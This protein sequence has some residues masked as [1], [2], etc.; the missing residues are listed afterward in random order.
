VCNES[1]YHV[2]DIL[3]TYSTFC[4]IFKTINSPERR[5]S[6]QITGRALFLESLKIFMRLKGVL[7]SIEKWIFSQFFQGKIQKF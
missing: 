5:T 3:D 2:E 6:P 1:L 7:K 4:E